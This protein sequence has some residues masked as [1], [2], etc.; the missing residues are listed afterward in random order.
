MKYIPAQSLVQQAIVDA[1]RRPSDRLIVLLNHR[2]VLNAHPNVTA[3]ALDGGPSALK[4]KSLTFLDGALEAEGYLPII[5]PEAASIL[6]LEYNI[7]PGR[8]GVSALKFQEFVLHLGVRM[9]VEALWLAESHAVK[10]A[11]VVVLFDRPLA[12]GAAYV[13]TQ[14]FDSLLAKYDLDHHRVSS[15]RY[16]ASY[17]LVTAANGKEECYTCEDQPSRTETAEEALALD[18]RTLAAMEMHPHIEIIG[19]DCDEDGKKRSVLARILAFLRDHDETEVKLLIEPIDLRDHSAVPV[20]HRL[21]HIEQR[22]LVAHSGAKGQNEELRLRAENEVP[23][24]PYACRGVIH[25]LTRK[26]DTDTPGKRIEIPSIISEA[27]Y[28]AIMR[29]CSLEP[30]TD[31]IEK[32]RARTFLRGEKGTGLR[33]EIDY[34]LGPSR[35][36]GKSYAELELPR[37]DFPY[38]HLLP[39]YVHVIEDVT[40]QKA[41][42]MRHLAQRD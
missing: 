11:N 17:H 21:V 16:H 4:S 39:S 35:H 37:P 33:L 26:L 32:L 27:G 10:G 20:P 1:K 15:H 9:E 23:G 12:G 13:Q 42:S 31:P 40:G 3:I 2:N 18:L 29:D 25:H 28:A 5:V 14:E 34:I 38:E 36:A 7:W 22:Y 30:D 19:N 6:M 8:N 41:H 24:H